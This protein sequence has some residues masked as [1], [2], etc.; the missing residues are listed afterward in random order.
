MTDFDPSDLGVGVGAGSGSGTRRS[1][2]AS[3]ILTYLQHCKLW[4]WFCYEWPAL[5]SMMSIGR[6]DSEVSGFAGGASL[7]S[8][9]SARGQARQGKGQNKL[10]RENLT[11]NDVLGFR[12][13]YSGQGQWTSLACWVP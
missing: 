12:P 5:S 2:T 4:S 7:P 10:A 9:C 6:L 11:Q 3:M 13:R 1:S 8:N